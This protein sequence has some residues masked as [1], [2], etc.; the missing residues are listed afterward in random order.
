MHCTCGR[1]MERVSVM[2]PGAGSHV[3]VD[4]CP[5]CPSGGMREDE[6]VYLGTSITSRD[7]VIQELRGRIRGLEATQRA[8]MEIIADLIE[9]N[10]ELTR[11]IMGKTH[12]VP[13]VPEKTAY[14]DPPH[15]WSC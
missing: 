8:N 15:D 10:R 4:R 11:F 7:E 3:M 1:E 9:A 2:M 6:K 13:K 5:V 12:D 14:D